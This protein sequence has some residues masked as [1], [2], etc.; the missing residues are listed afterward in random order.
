MSASLSSRLRRLEAATRPAAGDHGQRL[1]CFIAGIEW[2]A[3]E[4]KGIDLVTVADCD[5]ETWRQIQELRAHA[6]GD[7]R[8]AQQFHSEEADQEV[9]DHMARKRLHCLVRK[10]VSSLDRAIKRAKRRLGPSRSRS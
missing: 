1:V 3:F 9:L 7:W 8:L 2:S 6:S 4:E 5:A 10:H